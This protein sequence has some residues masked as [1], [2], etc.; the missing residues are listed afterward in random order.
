MTVP[1]SSSSSDII[2]SPI[3]GAQAE[4]TLSQA[5]RSVRESEYTLVA[6]T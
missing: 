2:Q 4:V 5:E 3:A 6:Q 1:P